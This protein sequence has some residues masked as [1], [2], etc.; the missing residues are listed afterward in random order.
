MPCLLTKLRLHCELYLCPSTYQVHLHAEVY[1]CP[2]LIPNSRAS[3]VIF[4]PC[5]RTKLRNTLWVIFMS[6]PLPSSPTW[7][8]IFMPCLRTILHPNSIYQLT[9][10]LILLLSNK[11]TPYA[12][13]RVSKSLSHIPQECH[14]TSLD[15]SPR[16]TTRAL[17]REYRVRDVSGVLSL[18]NFMSS[19]FPYC[20]KVVFRWDNIYVHT[21]C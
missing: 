5:L 10:Y 18:P 4:M 13:L 2:V 17:S 21:K 15:V 9:E 20:L 3:W 14:G 8:D 16:S 12:L 6:F 7:W 11:G 19:I 1:L